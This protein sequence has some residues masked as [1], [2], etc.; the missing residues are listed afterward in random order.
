M[1]TC[2]GVGGWVGGCLGVLVAAFAGCCGARST[3]GGCPAAD[4]V[5]ESA[6]PPNRTAGMML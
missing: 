4:V 1:L 6:T 3:V 2:V 5:R